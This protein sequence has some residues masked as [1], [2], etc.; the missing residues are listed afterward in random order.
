M[1][2][3]E[4]RLERAFLECSPVLSPTLLFLQLYIQFHVL[5]FTF[6]IL[7]ILTYH[8]SINSY[9]IY[10][11]PFSPERIIPIEPLLQKGNWQNSW[12]AVLPFTFPINSYTDTLGDTYTRRWTWSGRTFNSTMLQPIR[13][14]WTRTLL[15]ISK[16]SFRRKFRQRYFGTHTMWYWQCQI[17]CD[18]LSNL[19]ILFY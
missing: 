18:V 8:F 9:C 14:L 12:I 13:S 7:R 19:L 10:A 15:L 3:L 16:P 2:A 17:T 5:L 1:F 6:L 11:I 4:G